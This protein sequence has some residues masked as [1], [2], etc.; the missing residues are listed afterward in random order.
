[1]YIISNESF[2][3]N[4]FMYVYYYWIENESC[5]NNSMLTITVRQNASIFETIRNKVFVG[6]F[7]I[8]WSPNPRGLINLG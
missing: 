7:L 1:M 5:T 4:N 8:C 6:G 2:L 3:Y